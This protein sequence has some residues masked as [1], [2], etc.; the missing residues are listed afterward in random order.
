MLQEHLGYVADAARLEQFRQA[1]GLVVRRGDRVADLGCGSGVLGLIALAQHAAHVYAIDDSL[2]IEVARQSFARAGYA[3]RTTLIRG[4]SQ[5]VELPERVDVV[6]CDH[7]GHFGYDYGVVG[8]LKDASERFLKPGGRLIPSRIRLEV[9]A[10][11][12]RRCSEIVNGWQADGIPAELHW[13]RGHSVN[14]K[15]AVS[16]SRDDVLSPSGSLGDID[17]HSDTPGF[18]SWNA[19]LH[20]ERAG[21]MHGVAGWFDCELAE[22]V[23]MTN[24]PLAEKPIQ[25]PQAF[26]PI[27]EALQVAAGDVIKTTI[28]ARPADNLIAWVVESSATGQRFAHSTWQGMLMS[29]QG[30]A[31]A[32]PGHVPTLSREGQALV[33]VLG[34][35]DGNRTAEEVR[36]AVLRDHPDLF[37]SEAEISDFVFGAL[38]K[39]TE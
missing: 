13:L 34:Y 4:R 26:L 37:P 2:M 35:C 7:V 39:D 18:L 36:Q 5:R 22:G 23:W 9:A 16:F 20:I 21:A 32:N 27:G 12:G 33:K 25:R 1:I 11:G 10:V 3:D 29:P 30:L 14:A 31:R 17:L 8:V 6:L 38:G 19:E 24:S 28:M 15:H